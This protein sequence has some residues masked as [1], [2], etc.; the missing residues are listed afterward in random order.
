MARVFMLEVLNQSPL[1]QAAGSRL[2]TRIDAHQLRYYSARTLLTRR[3][4]YLL[5]PTR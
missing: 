5:G 3:G 2:L 1:P 4:A